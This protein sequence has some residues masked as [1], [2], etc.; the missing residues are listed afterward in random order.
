MDL[1]TGDRPLRRQR[2]GR[3]LTHHERSDGNYCCFRRSPSWGRK[4]GE[5][6]GM[7]GGFGVSSPGDHFQA[8]RWVGG[9]DACKL[10]RRLR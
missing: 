1:K 8:E 7:G 3:R 6:W 5:H 4:G 2:R 9:N 10:A